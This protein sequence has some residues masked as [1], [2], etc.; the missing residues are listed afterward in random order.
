MNL[1][2][3][4]IKAL[5][6][7]ASSKCT[8]K[9]PF[10]SRQQKI[11]PYGPHIIS[12]EAFKKLPAD[13]ISRLRRITFAG[14]F[15][16]FSTN[17][18]M[19]DIA[20]YVKNLNPG[21]VLGGDTNGMVQ[22][23]EWW[24]ALGS[25]FHDGGLIF[26]VDGLADTHALHRV[27]T[28]Y[29]AVIRNMEAF[30]RGGGVAF[31]KFIVFAHNEHQVEAAAR[32]AE[33]IGCAGFKAITSR[34]YND[35]LEPPRQI[36]VKLKREIFRD[37]ADDEAC[38][39]CNPI[40]KG[41]IYLAADGTVHPCCFAHCMYIT[42]H[43]RLFRFIVPLIDKYQDRINFKTRSLAEILSGPYFKAVLAASETNPY[44]RMKCNVYKQ[45]VRDELVVYERD[46][47]DVGTMRDVSDDSVKQKG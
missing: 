11:R 42:E 9:C 15:G 26:S 46:F 45:K 16:D 17:P 33:D 2:L 32:I 41:S 5:N 29:H 13:M 10:C 12:F 18:E 1:H 8:A 7:E 44:C 31:W 39:M 19:T 6:V 3:E 40:G 43:N 14:N 35:R 23:T 4:Q 38:A 34:D 25:S 36:D 22:S 47:R 27:G 28:D 20:A 30:I 37:Y 21:V 24:R